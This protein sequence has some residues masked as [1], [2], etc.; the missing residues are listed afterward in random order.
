MVGMAEL[1]AGATGGTGELSLKWL[2]GM[3]LSWMVAGTG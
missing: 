1:D 2:R 3:R